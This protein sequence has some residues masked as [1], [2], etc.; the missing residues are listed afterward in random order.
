[1]TEEEPGPAKD[2]VSE[3]SRRAAMVLATRN[4]KKA[5]EMFDEVLSKDPKDKDALNGRGVAL[6]ESKRVPESLDCFDKAIEIDYD[7]PDPWNN[8]GISL[9]VLTRYNEAIVYFD[10]ALVLR[11]LDRLEEAVKCCEKL[12]ELDPDFEDGWRL[13]AQCLK[14]MG[15]D[16]EATKAYQKVF[17][18]KRSRETK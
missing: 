2:E 3:G 1:M 9:M 10:K 13:K 7:F 16:E 5:L 4:V 12:N 17:E 11:E 14:V 6:Q 15:R 8:K 18:L